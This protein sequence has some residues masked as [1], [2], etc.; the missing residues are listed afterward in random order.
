MALTKFEGCSCARKRPV[1]LLI[2]HTFVYRGSPTCKL[3]AKKKDKCINLKT[4]VDAAT[5]L[6]FGEYKSRPKI[7]PLLFLNW[8][9]LIF[10]F[11]RKLL[12]FMQIPIQT[13]LLDIKLTISFRIG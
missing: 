3:S 6:K 11:V 2:F 8:A 5:F 12:A 4:Q 13:L 9:E 1:A 7:L 10:F